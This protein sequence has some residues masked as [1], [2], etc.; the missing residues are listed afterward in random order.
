MLEEVEVVSDAEGVPVTSKAA[1]P[2]ISP[3]AAAGYRARRDALREAETDLQGQLD[4]LASDPDASRLQAALQDLHAT[5]QEHVDGADAPDGPLAQVIDEAPWLAARV[6]RVR[7]E[8]AQL[9]DR[10]ADLLARVRDGAEVPASLAEAREV[11]HDVTRH[12]HHAADLL[13][14]AYMSDVPAGD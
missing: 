14:D 8:H 4:A 5:L 3:T 11:A 10:T 9:L 1:R 6:A 12:R 13:L 7:R 2:D